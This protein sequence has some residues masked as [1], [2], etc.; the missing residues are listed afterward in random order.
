MPQP[1][2]YGTVGGIAAAAALGEVGPPGGR[3]PGDE[4]TG[5]GVTCLP[6]KVT[7]RWPSEA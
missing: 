2:A 4:T 3:L 6:P 5:Y 7:T 1:T